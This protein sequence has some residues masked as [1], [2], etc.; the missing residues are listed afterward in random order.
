MNNPGRRGGEGGGRTGERAARSLFAYENIH[1]TTSRSFGRAIKDDGDLNL[2]VY[3]P[4][5]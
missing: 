2:S 3:R 5:D 1:G 4:S